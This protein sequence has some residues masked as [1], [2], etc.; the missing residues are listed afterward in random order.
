MTNN[1]HYIV[2]CV[3]DC[4]PKWPTFC[5]SSRQYLGGPKKRMHNACPLAD[6]STWAGCDV[7]TV[8]L[9]L[10]F[11]CSTRNGCCSTICSTVMVCELGVTEGLRRLNSKQ[12]LFSLF[13]TAPSTF[14]FWSRYASRT[15]NLQ[16]NPKI[17]GQC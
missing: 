2:V 8:V 15:T 3:F 4:T 12:T 1:E 9:D 17:L 7:K 11:L 6:F 10:V 5:L 16:E 13:P 14:H